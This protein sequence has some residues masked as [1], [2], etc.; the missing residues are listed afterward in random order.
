MNCGEIFLPLKMASQD[1]KDLSV[2]SFWNLLFSPFILILAVFLRIDFCRIFDFWEY[3]VD[4]I[5]A[6]ILSSLGY[7]LSFPVHSTGAIVITGAHTV[8][9]GQAAIELAE[10]GF[11]VFAGVP[12]LAG[13]SLANEDAHRLKNFVA[14]ERRNLI[15]PVLLD[16]T[17]PTHIQNAVQTVTHSFTVIPQGDRQLVAVI[18]CM[19]VTFTSPLETASLQDWQRIFQ[20]N[21]FGP[22]YVISAFLPM[23]R[24][25]CGRIINV[26][27]AAGLT[28]FPMNGVYSSS[29]TVNLF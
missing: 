5:Q 27:N 21:L 7:N 11:Y 17:N 28:A 23:L 13:S 15:I 14:P 10:K 22:F 3:F 1:P 18:N 8:I 12:A 29:K 9:G 26:S 6:T 25:S 4:S 2:F 20:L 19:G 16:V 24:Q